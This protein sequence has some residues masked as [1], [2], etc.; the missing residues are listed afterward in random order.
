MSCGKKGM[1]SN[2]L[3]RQLGLRQKTCWYLQRKMRMAMASSGGHPLQGHIQVDEFFVGGP[4]QGK[5]GSG[6]KKNH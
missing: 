2:E 6:N 4:E 1:S 5:P 3:S